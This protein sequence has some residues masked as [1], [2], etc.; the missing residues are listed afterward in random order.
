MSSICICSCNI[1]IRESVVTETI[2]IV[3]S[4]ELA[5]LILKLTVF[6]LPLSQFSM[7]EESQAQR[8][9]VTYQ[10]H[11]AFVLKPWYKGRSFKLHIAH[12]P[13]LCGA[14]ICLGRKKKCFYLTRGCEFTTFISLQF[15]Q[16]S[17]SF[18]M[19][20]NFLLI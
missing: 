2:I 9:C 6:Y 4:H 20:P 18:L 17:L 10:S 11:T 8:V 16:E 12:R 7:D 5:L 13:V 3:K 14:K 19:N 1:W 15:F